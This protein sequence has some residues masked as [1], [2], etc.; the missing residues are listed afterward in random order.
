MV[1]VNLEDRYVTV[2]AGCSWQTLHEH[3]DTDGGSNPLLG[4]ALRALR[5]GRGWLVTELHILGQRAKRHCRR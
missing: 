2:E 3:L 4:N 5:H 1:E